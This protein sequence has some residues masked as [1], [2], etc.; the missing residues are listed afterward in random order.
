MSR[1]TAGICA[2][3]LAIVAMTPL[4]AS[5][6]SQP[7]NLAAT[8]S[9]QLGYTLTHMNYAEQPSKP[10]LDTEMGDLHGAT[11]TFNRFTPRLFAHSSLGYAEGN[12]H[13]NGSR[14]TRFGDIPYRGSTANKVLT[15]EADIGPAFAIGNRDLIAPFVGTGVYYWRRDVGNGAPGGLTEKY[16]HWS[17]NVGLADRVAL[18][19]RLAAQIRGEA[20]YAIANGIVTPTGDAFLGHGWGYIGA[21]S[22][23]YRVL[24]PLE[25]YVRASVQRFR[26][27]RGDIA[28]GVYEPASRTLNAR[29]SVG[30]GYRF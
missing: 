21:V 22:L 19:A 17:A 23:H 26:F 3:M 9:L 13:Y 5:A 4:V 24:K 2:V 12:T 27:Q 11:L 6:H 7:N 18:T 8:S 14:Q 30:L 29:Y 10:Y 16:L 20:T 28:S 1:Y 25:V 15:Y